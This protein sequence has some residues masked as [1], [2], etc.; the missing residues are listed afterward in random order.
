[1]SGHF[2]CCDKISYVFNAMLFEEEIDISDV[3]IH[4][5]GKWCIEVY[6]LVVWV[7]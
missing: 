4:D 2:D 7:L 6:Q 3:F 5:F 1:M